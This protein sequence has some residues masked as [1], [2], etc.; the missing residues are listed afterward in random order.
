VTAYE[1]MPLRR[2]TVVYDVESY[3]EQKAL[4]FTMLGAATKALL[5]S[6]LSAMTGKWRR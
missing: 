2:L 6:M 4:L 1:E 5:F 3:H